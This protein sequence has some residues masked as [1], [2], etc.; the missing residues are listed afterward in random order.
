[1]TMIRHERCS[2][3]LIYE[4]SCIVLHLLIRYIRVIMMVGEYIVLYILLDWKC[5]EHILRRKDLFIQRDHRI[6]T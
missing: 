1:M 5:V 6:P 3:L 2:I 4:L